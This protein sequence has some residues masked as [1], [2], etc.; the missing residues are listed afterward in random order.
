MLKRKL[1]IIFLLLGFSIFINQSYA[2]VRTVN[3]SVSVDAFIGEFRFSLFGY[4]SPKAMVTLDGLGIYDRTYADTTGYFEFHNRFSP[5]SPREACLTSQ[6]QLGRITAPTCLPPFPTKYNTRIGP[7]LIPPTLSLDK[8]NYWVDDEVKLT[9]QTTPNSKINL[10]MFT[11]QSVSTSFYQ[12][13]SV[14]DL[15]PQVEAFS[16]APLETTADNKGNFSISLPSSRPESFRLFAQTSYDNGQSP[17]S[18]KLNIRILP[19]WMIIIQLLYLVW[20]IIKSRL[21]EIIIIGELVAITIFF[22]RRYLHPHVLSRYPLM[23]NRFTQ[24]VLSK[25]IV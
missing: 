23:K 18:I 25:S 3:P 5:Q 1:L 2:S 24:I 20:S 7:V 22:I 16:F 13:L 8:E 11:G 10:S 4:T 9:G 21:L 6:D 15:I 17:E 14:S 19:F 12:F